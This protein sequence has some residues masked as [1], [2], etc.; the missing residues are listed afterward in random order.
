MFQHKID[1]IF[2][3]MPNVFGTAY[4]ILVIGYDKNGADHDATVQNVLWQCEEVNL[5][6]NKE[7]FHFRCTSTPFFW[8]V[9]SRDGIQPDPQKIKVLMDMPPM[10]VIPYAS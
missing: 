9:I 8:E 6:L 10:Y 1:K 5:K 4:D 2:S 7:N 3:N